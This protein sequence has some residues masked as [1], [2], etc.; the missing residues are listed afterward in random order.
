MNNSLFV[1]SDLPVEIWADWLE[2]QG[3]DTSDLRAW[4]AMGL[5]TDNYSY[6]CSHNYSDNTARGDSEGNGYGYGDGRDYTKGG[7]DGSGFLYTSVYDKSMGIGDGD[8]CNT[9]NGNGY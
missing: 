3:Q 7:D 9:G 6:N 5:A 2:E 4:L 8:G 1:S